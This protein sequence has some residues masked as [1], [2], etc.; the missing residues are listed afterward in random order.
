M[1]RFTTGLVAL[2]AAALTALATVQPVQAADELHPLPDTTT[3]E[4]NEECLAA[5]NSYRAR[6]GAPPLV[7]DD[8]AVAHAMQRAAAASTLDGLSTPPGPGSRGYGE[9]RYWFATYENEP[10]TCA[11]AV[12]LWYEARWTGGYDWDRPGYSPDTGSFT[13][14]VWKDTDVLGCG[15]ASGH[16]DGGEAHHT[17]IVC[18]YGPAGNIIGRFRANVGEPIGG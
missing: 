7:L 1:G 11:E 10:A 8:A 12:K 15:R 2:A 14:V 13:Q 9:N 18:S 3:E 5:H 6:H 17:F 4:F 16:R